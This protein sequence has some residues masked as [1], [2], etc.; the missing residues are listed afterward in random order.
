MSLPL[1]SVQCVARTVVQVRATPLPFVLLSFNWGGYFLATLIAFFAGGG[2]SESEEWRIFVVGW[3]IIPL[4]APIAALLMA[5]I[6]RVYYAD[7]EAF[8]PLLLTANALLWVVYFAYYFPPPWLYTYEAMP[9]ALRPLVWL[10]PLANVLVLVGLNFCRLLLARCDLTYLYTLLPLAALYLGLNFSGFQTVDPS[11]MRISWPVIKP[12]NAETSITHYQV[13]EGVEADFYEGYP[14]NTRIIAKVSGTLKAELPWSMLSGAKI[15]AWHVEEGEWIEPSSVFVEFESEYFRIEAAARIPILLKKKGYLVGEEV[16]PGSDFGLY[17]SQADEMQTDNK[18]LYAAFAL[19][20]VSLLSGRLKMLPALP[21]PSVVID[22]AVLLAVALLVLDLDYIYDAHHYNFFLGPINDVLRAKSLLVDINC[23]YGVGVIYFLA[24]LFKLFPIPFNYQGFSLLLG[25]LQLAQYALFYMLMRRVFRSQFFSVAALVVIVAANYYSQ[26]ESTLPS[27]GPLRF[28]LAYVLLALLVTRTQ[29]GRQRWLSI[30]IYATIGLSSLWSFEAFVYTIAAYFC[31][32]FYILLWNPRAIRHKL[33]SVLPLFGGPAIAIAVSHLLLSV[34][35]YL[36]AGVWPEWSQYFDYIAL[37]SVGEYGTMTVDAWRPWALY[38][39]VYFLS[40][41]LVL[42]KAL[43]A[44]SGEAGPFACI[45]GLTGFGIVQFTYFLGRSHHN[46]LYHI[47]IPLIA[48]VVYWFLFMQRS[49]RQIPRGFAPSITYCFCAVAFVLLIKTGPDFVA[50]WQRSPLYKLME[51]DTVTSSPWSAGPSHTE[52]R[53]ALA[54]IERSAAADERIA[55]FLSPE[56]TTEA[57]MLSQKAH[58]FPLS[59]PK[60][61]ELL[62]AAVERA[63]HFDHGLKE[64]DL[65]FITRNIES[66]SIAQE[67]VVDEIL[68]QFNGVHLE[69]TDYVQTIRLITPHSTNPQ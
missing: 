52:V 43:S 58:I 22:G 50:K 36:R 3:P 19:A 49:S 8:Y 32:E 2:I 6:K 61:D 69:S 31:S 21:L 54:L 26:L 11:P 14:L 25:I 46:N 12:G 30:A 53:D 68:S 57:L 16:E 64:G 66:L 18:I 34:F 24:F 63:Q 27:T 1:T 67:K 15:T 39:A 17:Y 44:S 55:L 10:M 20:L 40:L 28:G 38:I 23:Q 48:L 65:F 60:Q 29:S 51:L 41:L 62:L 37:Y 42:Y 33:R 7:I 45:A 56:L 35:T 13:T 9:Q 5:E 47:C 59:N 4:L